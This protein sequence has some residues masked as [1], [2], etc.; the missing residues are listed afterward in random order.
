[1]LAVIAAI[2]TILALGAMVLTAMWADHIV[3][4]TNLHKC[5][6]ANV[7]VIEVLDY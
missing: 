6:L 4:P 3:T 7:L 5:L 2:T 1:M